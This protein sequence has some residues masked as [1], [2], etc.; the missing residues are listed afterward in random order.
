MRSALLFAARQGVP[1]GAVFRPF[2]A[3]RWTGPT[4]A[5]ATWV[6]L[7]E[8]GQEVTGGARARGAAYAAV[9]ELR[10][11]APGLVALT[12][13]Y[14]SDD[15]QAVLPPTEVAWT[16]DDGH[17]VLIHLPELVAGEAGP[18]PWPV[19]PVFTA[20]SA[21]VRVAADGS[22]WAHDAMVRRRASMGFVA[23]IAG[24]ATLR[25]RVLG[26]RLLC[27]WRN[28]I[29]A[30]SPPQLLAATPPGRLDIDPGFGLAACAWNEPPPV[31]P[32]GPDGASPAAVTIDLQEGAT[33]HA[34][35]R[36]APREPVLDLRLPTPT[37]LVSASGR[38]SRG[39]PASFHRVPRYRS[40][41]EALAAIS[42]AWATL[43]PQDPAPVEV[44]QFEDSATY[45]DEAPVWPGSIPLALRGSHAPTLVI[46]AAEGERPIV[47]ID[48]AAGW[49]LPFQ[50]PPYARIAISGIAF[51]APGWAGT[52][53][54]PARD[55][56]L[57]LTTVLHAENTI[58]FS[59]LSAAG[60]GS[61][62]RVR[63][64]ETAGLRLL[65][66]G[67]LAVTDSIVDAGGATALSADLGHLSVER[68]TVA[69][70]VLA[71]QLEAS[72]AIF[73]DNVVVEDRFT[74][75]VRYSRVTGN[76]VLPRRHALAVDVPVPFVSLSR[77]APGWRRLREDCPPAVL[78]GGAEGN[79][80]GGHA[81]L[82]RGERIAAF[83]RRLGQFTPAGMQTGLIRVD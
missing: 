11:A 37:R 77:R 16:G 7:D 67:S 31:S 12:V 10:D 1:G 45:P 34:G 42:A 26:A 54:P 47:A 78:H 71:F 18:A 80:M 17:T 62:V 63:L 3:L 23:P 14:A 30:A 24:S 28:E 19:D 36:P 27:P 50:P 21:A 29:P 58:V 9:T 20:A 60:G 48:P 73:L 25:R 32:P 74:G 79:E 59:A 46:Q 33:L 81:V 51:G 56:A 65:G 39:A 35:A 69:G 57:D 43:A 82:R 4:P 44:V 66:A 15:P 41:T 76:S 5:G 13:L 70:T 55:A 64:S 2:Q 49:S 61:T 22:T 75:C 38:L 40:L 53:L 6:V 72:E 52:R 8:N 68:C 83:R